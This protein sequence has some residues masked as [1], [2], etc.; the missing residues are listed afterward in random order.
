MILF[1]HHRYRAT[2][3]EE[4]AVDDLLWL[5]RERLGE[6]AELL[7]RR[8]DTV[9]RGRAALGV[10][11]GGLEPEEVGAAVRRTGARIV[12]AHNLHPTFGWRALAAA[13]VAG[14]AVVLHLHQYR[15]VCAIGVCHRDGHDCTRCHGR[16]TLPG[17]A[18]NCRGSWPEALAYGAGLAL[19]QRR[20]TAQ[21]QITIV[22][23]RFAQERLQALGAP[24]GPAVVVPNPIRAPE[25]STGPPRP[26]AETPGTAG[27]PAG[28]YALIAS[29]LV[30]EKGIAVAVEACTAAGLPLVIAGD[31]PERARLEPRYSP[32]AVR[33]VGQVDRHTLD[34]LRADATVALVPSLTAETFGLAAAEAMAAGLP[35]IASRVGALPELVGDEWLVEPGDASA[36]LAAI[37]RIRTQPEAGARA[38]ERAVAHAGP[39]VVAARL[40][41]VYERAT[42]R[43]ASDAG[44]SVRLT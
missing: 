41:A 17:I 7:T 10:I 37:D 32:A 30:A 33:F 40:T 36:L 44:S 11:G 16:N 18:L 5:V 19:W 28:G 13:R 1:L 2:G 3:G 35:V 39:D 31:G 6:D 21:A 23:S 8:S 9:G 34:R 25:T 24:L 22:P 14:A 43:R 20:M 26:V 42:A 27:P 29:R 15:L 4:R 12:H 38:R